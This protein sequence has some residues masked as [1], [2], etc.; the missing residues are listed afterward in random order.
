MTDI[1]WKDSPTSVLY[2][3]ALSFMDAQI[4]KIREGTSP[5]CVW[6]LEHEPLY[7]LGT[8]A[9]EGDVLGYK[10]IPILKANRGGRSTYHGP[11]QRV[12]YVMLNLKH[13]G[14]DIKRF[15]WILEEWLI[16]T[17][18]HFNIEGFR[19]PGRVG[20][21]VNHPTKGECKIAAIG[22]RVRHWITFH[23]VS[24]NVSPNLD[25]YQGIVPCGIEEYGVTS[26]QNLGV[27]TDYQTVD[28][29]LKETFLKVLLPCLS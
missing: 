21:W 4:S 1:F 27:E 13:R 16:Q 6:F 12:A 18:H 24:L 15:V 22:L 28:A 14:S 9:Q 7:T 19:S 11:G 25:H 29:V 5:E 2:E 8:S 20:I 3:E 10:D 26:L 23:G 17:L